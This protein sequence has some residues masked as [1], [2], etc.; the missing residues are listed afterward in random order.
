[1]GAFFLFLFIFSFL[2]I[3]SRLFS[4]VSF[5]N[6]TNL[7]QIRINTYNSST[8][9]HANTCNSY[10]STPVYLATDYRLQILLYTIPSEIKKE[11][12]RHLAWLVGCLG[13]LGLCGRSAFLFG[14]FGGC[15]DGVLFWLVFG[16]FWACLWCGLINCSAFVLSCVLRAFFGFVWCACFLGVM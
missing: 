13:R 5:W 3:V 6:I 15:L 8:T 4:L 11:T 7:Q 2:C 1:M 10:D 14:C 12:P 9:T 16:L